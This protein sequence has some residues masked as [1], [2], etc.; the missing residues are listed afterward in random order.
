MN[1][2]RLEKDFKRLEIRKDYLNY[3]YNKNINDLKDIYKI[4]KIEFSIEEYLANLSK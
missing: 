4:N 2:R 1:I 3:K